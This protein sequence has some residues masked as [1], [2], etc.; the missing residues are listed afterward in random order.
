MRERKQKGGSKPEINQ[1]TLP[2]AWIQLK[3]PVI[4]MSNVDK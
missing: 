4:R 3:Y 2:G 1:V